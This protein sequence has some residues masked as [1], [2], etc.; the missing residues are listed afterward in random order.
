MRFGADATQLGPLLFGG[1]LLAAGSLFVA[2]RLA[3]S[4]GFVRTMAFTHLPGNVLLML[5]PLMPS[6]EAAAAV[7]L[8]RF[9]L[10][11]MDVPTRQA[12][13]LSLAA[14]VDR[15]RAVGL[16]TAV[17]PAAAA[18]SPLFAGLAVQGA[19]LGVPFFVAGGL[20]IA[21]DLAVLRLFAHHPSAVVGHERSEA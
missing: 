6:F 18:L 2:E 16:T 7:L 1:N 15:T 12:F 9:A 13:T 20:K 4:I 21:Y 3:R 19:A 5:V 17:R 14:P 10:S 11:Q 8:A